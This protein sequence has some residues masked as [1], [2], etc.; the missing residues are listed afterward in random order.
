MSEKVKIGDSA[1][2]FILVDMDR[3]TR[4][5][6]DFRGMSVVMAFYPGAFTFACKKGMRQRKRSWCHPS[7]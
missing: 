3:E 7:Q 6:G 2:D 5:L 1:P 4:S